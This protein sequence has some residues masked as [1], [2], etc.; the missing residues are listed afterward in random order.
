[1]EAGSGMVVQEQVSRKYC[2]QYRGRMPERLTQPLT[3]TRLSKCGSWRCQGQQNSYSGS[4]HSEN[5]QDPVVRC[6]PQPSL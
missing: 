2:W 5:I 4:S 3:N 6:A 1:M